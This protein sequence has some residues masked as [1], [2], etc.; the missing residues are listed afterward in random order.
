MD[1]EA[2]N[3]GIRIRGGCGEE[4]ISEDEEELTEPNVTET[5]MSP[6]DVTRIIREAMR[7]DM[8]PLCWESNPGLQ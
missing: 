8:P 7:D 5:R 3:I 4:V 1:L 2:E 6:E